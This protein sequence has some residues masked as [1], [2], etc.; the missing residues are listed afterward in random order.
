M[1]E[2]SDIHGFLLFFAYTKQQI[3]SNRL[4]DRIY[5]I[6]IGFLDA[7]CSSSIARTVTGST[8]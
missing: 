4:L 3:L 7:Y 8:G 5:S 1:E 6:Y 2:L